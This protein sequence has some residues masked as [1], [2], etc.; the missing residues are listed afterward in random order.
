VIIWV[1]HLD[2]YDFIWVSYDISNVLTIFWNSLAISRNL[3]WLNILFVPSWILAAETYWWASS[4]VGRQDRGLSQSVWL[5]TGSPPARQLTTTAALRGSRGHA[6]K[7]IRTRTR[8]RTYLCQCRQEMVIGVASGKLDCGGALRP[9]YQYGH[10]WLRNAIIGSR[11]AL[12]YHEADLV[13]DADDRGWRQDHS[14]RF[15]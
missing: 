1:Y 9:N 2:F 11:N 15:R 3:F 7:L 8:W 14:S 5:V 6:R 4:Q 12:A 10:R 13:V